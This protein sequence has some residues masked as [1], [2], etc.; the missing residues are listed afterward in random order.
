[1]SGFEPI[2]RQSLSESIYQALEARILAQ[3]L[4]AGS[5]LPAER[6]LAEAMGVNRGAIREAIKRLQQAGLVAVR[7]GGKSVVL[8][9]EA[10]GGLDLLPRLLVD[11]QGRLNPG[12]AR[13][14]LALRAS[15]APDV[16]AAA[17]GRRRGAAEL[18]EVV[19]R[20][21]SRGDELSALQEDA[22]AY[23]G[24]L[25]RH[26]GNLAYRLAF[27]SL[28]RTYRRMWDLLR[29]LLAEE[30]RDIETLAE[31]AQAIGKGDVEAA[32]RLAARHVALGTAALQRMLDAAAPETGT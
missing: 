13:S 31:L 10:Q 23:W 15:L 8:D 7:Q 26:S 16:A 4:E 17:A 30:F 21:R 20:M 1:M 18:S 11:Q 29:P 24:E 27:N 28:D 32:R 3:E 2:T 6:E 22:M 19:A 12:V 14:I 9:F 25:V 5:A